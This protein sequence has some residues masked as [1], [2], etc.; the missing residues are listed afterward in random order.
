VEV[1][2]DDMPVPVV[3]KP[4]GWRDAV[5]V[6]LALDVDEKSAVSDMEGD[7]TLVLDDIALDSLSECVVVE[8]GVPGED[9]EGGF[10][11]SELFVELYIAGF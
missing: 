2:L 3:D 10:V 5:D 8:E 11:E 6:P 9:D 7:G 4:R 1:L